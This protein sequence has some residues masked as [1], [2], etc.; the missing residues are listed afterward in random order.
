MAPG[1][2]SL[3]GPAP[4]TAGPHTS[5]LLNKL[6]PTVDSQHG[7]TQI[8]GPGIN[9]NPQQNYSNA[10]AHDRTGPAPSNTQ[11]GAGN[12]YGPQH[13]SRLANE[14]DPRVNTTNAQ[15]YAP[16]QNAGVPPPGTQTG[17]GNNYGPQ[18]NSHL[19]NQIDPRVDTNYAGGGVPQRRPVPPAGTQTGVGN[20]YDYEP[21]HN[22]RLA[23]EVD[24]RVDNTNRD[25]Y[26]PQRG[27]EAAPPGG[28][29]GVPRTNAPEGT[30]GPH[31]SRFANAADPRFDSDR[32]GRAAPVQT[33]MVDQGQG[34]QPG[35][36]TQ[37]A[38]PHHSNLLNKLDP[39]VRN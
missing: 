22:S 28:V 5:D 33:S 30:H 35:P 7:G 11:I 10:R 27:Y 25:G 32:D 4:N 15:G 1:N 14:V 26:A 2:G 19:A 23:N 18:H 17:M 21:Q 20:N 16:P 13:N 8:L 6:D 12:S 24:P 39:S 38:G 3:P 36:A 31:S 37:T 29:S 34:V 9:S